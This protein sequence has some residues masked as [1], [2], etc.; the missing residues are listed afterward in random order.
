MQD[1]EN[2]SGTPP[3]RRLSTRLGWLLSL[4]LL[5]GIVWAVPLG[6]VWGALEEAD[7]WLLAL[8]AGPVV[9]SLWLRGG[10]WALL[11]R[12]RY[13]IS[14]PAAL[15]PALIGLALN[16]VLP[17]KAGEVAKV[18]LAAKRFGTGVPFTLST[19]V[20]ERL[21]DAVTLLAFLGG[22]LLV[23]PPIEGATEAEILGY[24]VSPEALTGLTRQIGLASAL[25]IVLVLT[26]LIPASRE[27]LAGL[28]GAL[29]RIGPR[30]ERALG[31]AGQGLGALARPAIVARVLGAS[32][33]IWLALSLTNLL[34][35]RAM[36]GIDLDFTQALVVTAISIAASAIPSV[37]GSWGV[38]EA[39]A[40]LALVLVHANPEPGAGVA[41][42][43]ASHLCQYLP[44]V[45]LGAVAGFWSRSGGEAPRH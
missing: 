40:L 8:A 10:R 19:V 13:T 24:S 25:L 38:Y 35:A 30:A 45:V 22:A 34:V 2:T 7:P 20:G 39:G 12:P 6:D 44:V 28:A 27:R 33:L 21:L 4:V 18:A 3:K 31:E 14:G 5:A 23:L 43:F 17:G 26:L 16:A 9:A 15:R 37:P 36:P 41:F 29:P 1:L 32:L 42:A 11:F